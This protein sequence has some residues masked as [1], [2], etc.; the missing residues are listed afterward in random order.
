MVIKTLLLACLLFATSCSF[1]KSVWNAPPPFRPMVRIAPAPV[2]EIAAIFSDDDSTSIAATRAWKS[3]IL[4]AFNKVEGRNPNLLSFGE[5]RL[6]VESGFIRIGGSPMNSADRVISLLEFLGFHDRVTSAGVATLLDWFEGHRT[7]A[8]RLHHLLNDPARSS[9]HLQTRELF[10]LIHFAGSVFELHGGVPFTRDEWIRWLAPWIPSELPHAK[11]ALPEEVAL[12]LGLSATV[13]GENRNWGKCLH[14]LSATFRDASLAVDY[15]LGRQDPRATPEEIRHSAMLLES[16]SKEW[17]EGHPPLPLRRITRLASA[18][19]VPEPEGESALFDWVPVLNPGSERDAISAELL[20]RLAGMVSKAILK[21][22]T[23]A[24]PRDRIHEEVSSWLLERTRGR[25][26]AEQLIRLGIRLIDTTTHLSN[27]IRAI[28]ELP[29]DPSSVAHSLAPH[30][31]PGIGEL[32]Q[33]GSDLLP[34]REAAPAGLDATGLLAWMRLYERLRSL[35]PRGLVDCG[36]EF[37]DDSRGKFLKRRTVLECLPRMVRDEFPRVYQD[38]LN[39]GFERTCGVVFD[40]ILPN[41]DPG[42]I[43]LEVHD[44]DIIP[45][46]GMLFERI[47]DFC[48]ENRNGLLEAGGVRAGEKRCV[49]AVGVRIADALMDADF[50]KSTPKALRFLGWIRRPGPASRIAESGLARGSLSGTSWYRLLGS[51]FERMPASPGSVLSFLAEIMN[52]EKTRAIDLDQTGPLD[53]PGT[54]LLYHRELSR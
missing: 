19:E 12:L 42:S 46:A 45:L 5:I 38:C 47:Y 17:F 11:S 13:C 22:E 14:D 8:R 40:E 24:N 52:T 2:P 26:Q 54:E 51:L 32:L 27:L 15:I 49:A 35:N 43:E 50:V 4:D 30:P 33:I 10:E 1:I 41:P 28:R 6:L 37:R 7:E 25:D 3:L 31:L 53:S 36:V 9:R 16:R 29:L 44:A 48:D 39:W 34:D 18:L 21:S 20:V 23:G